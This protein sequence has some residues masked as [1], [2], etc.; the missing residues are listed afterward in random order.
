[1][2]RRLARAVLI[3]I[4]RPR[5][6]LTTSTLILMPL[7]MCHR[8]ENQVLKLRFQVCRHVLSEIDGDQI[9][10]GV[11]LTILLFPYYDSVACARDTIRLFPG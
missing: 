7:L 8:L 9:G 11:A 6:P 3:V 1:M 4:A 5:I 2:R 10:M